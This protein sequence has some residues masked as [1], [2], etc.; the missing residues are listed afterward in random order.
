MVDPVTAIIADTSPFCRFAEAGVCEQFI[1]FYGQRLYI[2]PQVT[3]ELEHRA[4]RPEHA[5]LQAIAR[6]NPPW[7]PNACLSLN[8]E[9][10]RRADVL[11]EGWRKQHFKKTGHER[12]KRANLGEATSIVACQ[13]YGGQL[14][15]DDGE[16]KRFA[17]AKGLSV[18]TTEDVIIEMTAGGVFGA[19]RG[20]ITWGRVYGKSDRAEFEAALEAYRARLAA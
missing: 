15:L 3:A 14:I 7:V 6:G 2:T 20:F 4:T 12:D 18:I 5:A 10:F 9:E 16:P 17:A 13:R 1:D 8:E 11:A 19:T